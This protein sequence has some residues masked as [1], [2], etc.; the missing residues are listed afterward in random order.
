MPLRQHSALPGVVAA[1]VKKP[2]QA[3][4]LHI[5]ALDL[6]PTLALGRA[7]DGDASARLVSRTKHRVP[8][9]ADGLAVNSID[10]VNHNWERGVRQLLVDN[11]N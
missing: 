6:P 1:H 5:Q 3:V 2:Y 7:D 8:P 4:E 9:Q 10:A 11:I